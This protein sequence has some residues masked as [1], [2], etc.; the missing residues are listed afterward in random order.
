MGAGA[1]GAMGAMAAGVEGAGAEGAGGEGA[2]GP[3]ASAPTSAM[4]EGGAEGAGETARGATAGSY[5]ETLA[6]ARR[7][8][9]SQRIELL[10]SAIALNPGGHEALSDLAFALLN[11]GRGDDMTQAAQY[12]ERATQLDPSDALAWLV[13]GAS[14]DARRD[15][16]GAR[17]AY[18]AC[19]DQGTGPHVR[20]CRAMLR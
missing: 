6:E 7:A 8:R 15:R 9:G 16:A 18:Q 3:A 20:E 19:V 2:T 14:R 12:A 17:T 11:R 5:E 13:L 1:E 4:A 10:Q